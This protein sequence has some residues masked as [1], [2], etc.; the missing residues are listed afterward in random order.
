MFLVYNG[1]AITIKPPLIEDIG[2]NR[3][4]S[5]MI[6]LLKSP[7][8][9]CATFGLFLNFMVSLKSKGNNIIKSV[10]SPAVKK[11]VL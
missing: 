3:A 4:T 9:R 5:W 1:M 6:F 10:I 2:P 8:T 11:T 7:I